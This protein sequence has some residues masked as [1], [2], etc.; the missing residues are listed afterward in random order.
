MVVDS[1]TGA[2]ISGA[3]V[4]AYS[5]DAFDPLASH[6]LYLTDS[7]GEVLVKERCSNFAASAGK[8]GYNYGLSYDTAVSEGNI[9]VSKLKL[10]PDDMSVRRPAKIEIFRKFS[11]D[12]QTQSIV[13]QMNQYFSKRNTYM[14]TFGEPYIFEAEIYVIDK[15]TN[16]PVAD[17]MLFVR[18]GTF[19]GG[20]F[21]DV[22][23][24]N[25]EGI[26]K[27]S[28]DLLS[29]SLHIDTG[30]DGYPPTKKFWKDQ[31]KRGSFVVYLSKD[32]KPRSKTI[33]LADTSDFSRRKTN[34][35]LWEKFKSYYKKSG[36]SFRY[37][38]ETR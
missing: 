24:T 9:L 12:K 19:S 25:S 8:E 7:N 5:Y 14:A 21:E 15:D 35:R 18:S 34:M 22:V 30:K 4:Y 10:T 33:V 28:I 13:K 38:R 6:G 32:Y 17:A 29:P 11:S 27:V 3:F 26:A 36:G 1:Q 2:P 23:V 31:Y 16:E 20:R 37:L